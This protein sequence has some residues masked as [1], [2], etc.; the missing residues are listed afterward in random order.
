MNLHDLHGVVYGIALLTMNRFPQE[1]I[2]YEIT[3][4]TCRNASIAPRQQ[5]ARSPINGC[6]LTLRVVDV[7]A[8]ITVVIGELKAKSL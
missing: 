5:V 4:I 3:G 6:L 1:N 2:I 8:S 7:A